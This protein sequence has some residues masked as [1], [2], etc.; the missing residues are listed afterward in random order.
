M[1]KYFIVS[2]FLGFFFQSYCQITTLP[3]ECSDSVLMAIKGKYKQSGNIIDPSISSVLPS[4]QQKEVWNRLEVMHQMLLEAYPVPTGFESDWGKAMSRGLF[5]QDAN[6][7]KGNP[8]CVY[9]Y[10]ANFNSYACV[11][12]KSKDLFCCEPGTS[13]LRVVV[14]DLGFISTGMKMDAK[15]T[16]NGL[17]FS[18]RNPVRGSWKGYELIHGDH[19]G[20]TTRMILIHRPGALPYIPVTRKQYLDFCIIYLNNFYDE[21]INSTNL[22]PVRSLEVQKSLKNKSLDKIDE[23]YKNDPKKRDIIRKNF[24]DTY[25]TDQQRRDET[26]NIVIK[27]KTDVLKRYN[28]E[29]EKTKRDGLLD[30]PAFIRTVAGVTEGEPIF[31]PESENGKMLIT[32]N[33]AY[34][35]KD[36]PKYMPQFIVMY[37][38]WSDYLP[39]GGAA[40]MYYRKMLEEN[41]PIEKLQAMIDK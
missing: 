3:V 20:S 10:K 6:L 39:V 16:I 1:N 19:I 24:L 18:I 38:T 12:N 26:V 4:S 22:M 35:R 40:G 2:F 30:S 31:I 23:D 21:S 25:K 34:I 36:L 14:N 11:Q 29:L 27:N 7:T 17:P 8:V 41:F 13:Q 37:W 33:P 5:A 32:E 9:T 15:M 28:D